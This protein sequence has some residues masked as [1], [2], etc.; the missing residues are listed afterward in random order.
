[1]ANPITT[2]TNTNNFERNTEIKKVA[3]NSGAYS[4]TVHCTQ[5]P[6]VIYGHLLRYCEGAKYWYWLGNTAKVLVFVLQYWLKICIGIGHGIGIGNTFFRQYWYWYCQ[7]F[8]K[9]LLT[10]LDEIRMP[11]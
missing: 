11:D 7:Y 2:N 1:L 6:V 4:A 5:E 9:V 10:T 8:V 3:W